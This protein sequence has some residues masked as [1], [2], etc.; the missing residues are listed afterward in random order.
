MIFSAFLDQTGQSSTWQEAMTRH[1]Q[2][3]GLQLRLETRHLSNRSV[4]H[5][6]W[7]VPEALAI[8]IS[9]VESTDQLL[10]TTSGK[11][12]SAAQTLSSVTDVANQS[13][14]VLLS[15][16]LN[17]IELRLAVPLATPEQFYFAQHL[18]S[19]MLG[20]DLRLLSRW[21]G[22]QLNDSAV[23]AL[24]QYGTIP[25]PLTIAKN[26]HRIPNGHQLT[27]TATVGEPK[28]IRYFEPPTQLPTLGAK[29][30]DRKALLDIV[31]A[32]LRQTLIPLPQNSALYFSG[33]VDSALLAAQLAHLGR[34]DITLFNYSFGPDDMESRLASEIADFLGFPYERISYQ[35]SDM[36]SMLT[37]LAKD[38]SFP[39]GDR[40]VVPTNLLVHASLPKLS[41]G[42]AIID[43]TGADGAFGA[44]HTTNPLSYVPRP[45]RWWLGKI[46]KYTTLWRTT[47]S[48]EY[49]LHRAG[50]S[51][52]MTLPHLMVI[53]SYAFSDIIYHIPAL[54]R[55]DLENNLIQNTDDLGLALASPERFSLLDL[56][57]V[58]AGM[59]AAKTFDPLRSQGV[60]PYYPFLEPTMVRL[61]LAVPYVD[62]C[63]N[64]EAKSLLKQLLARDI[65]DH[66]I[67][68]QKSG[69]IAPFK[70][71]LKNK[72]M[73]EFIHDVVLSPSNPLLDYC[74]VDLIT[75]MFARANRGFPLSDSLYGFLWNLIF[76]SGWL[77]Q[78]NLEL[79]ERK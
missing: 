23:F 4:L 52:H 29:N 20:N 65:P 32:T 2:W 45:I 59:F 13:N 44:W 43:G 19:I 1:A 46:Y 14:E 51:L 7:L 61:A 49:R 62:K 71:M 53:G 16:C 63:P 50:Q 28:I 36:V 18:Q 27:F 64:H 21:K 54:I 74:N 24:F 60:T 5:F 12:S 67:Y 76:T 58:C 31:Q 48:L 70:E 8:N 40:S 77:N 15:I 75:R 38:Y 26:I 9:F 30:A 55:A 11:T 37:R 3:L 47:S 79:R 17:A 69:F 10:L 6:G 39:F 22:L 41:V 33:G 57:H 73:Q 56:I 35:P 34:R 25:A 78:M 72:A 66:W 42:S 68:R